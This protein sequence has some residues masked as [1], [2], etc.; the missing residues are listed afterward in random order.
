M[1]ANLS[2]RVALTCVL[3]IAGSQAVVAQTVTIAWD[4]PDDPTVTGFVVYYGEVS[5]SYLAS[6]N[7]GMATQYTFRNL[8][9]GSTYFFTVKS[10]NADHAMSAPAGEIST[11]VSSD[12]V[13]ISNDFRATNPPSRLRHATLFD[14]D[15]DARADISVF[16]PSAGQWYVLS[17]ANQT[18]WGVVSF[19]QNGDVPLS[20]DFDGDRKM[21]PAVYR[22]STGRWY[23]LTSSTH[24]ASIQSYTWGL[25]TDVPLAADFDGDGRADIV[26]YRPSTG[27]WYILRSSTAYTQWWTRKWGIDLTAG[28]GT[29]D[30]PVPADYDGDG[31]ADYAVYRPSKGVWYVLLSTSG[32]LTSTAVKWGIDTTAL[33]SDYVGDGSPDRPVAAD[34]DGDGRAD[35]AVF[36]AASGMWYILK[37]STGLQQWLTAK[38]G[39]SGDV[40]VP[41]DYNGDGLTDIAVFRPS[42]GTWFFYNTQTRT[43]WGLSTDLPLQRR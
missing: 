34:Y 35:F 29:A 25:A 38:W 19:G 30:L 2:M 21:D 12:F 31:L 37:S 33:P 9:V 3:L 20:A 28:G 42:T 10:S 8:P 11:V 18:P 36:R 27:M 4:A 43:T 7:V 13:Q 14:Y 41:A 26:I 5:G 15:G 32:F 24:Y 22:P 39:M 16:R 1:L 23:F 6:A 17:G 40:A